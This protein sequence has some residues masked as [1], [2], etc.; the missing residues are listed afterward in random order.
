MLMNWKNKIE[1]IMKKLFLFVLMAVIAILP[2]SC[3]KDEPAPIII[4]DIELSDD[5]L[6]FDFT[7]GVK[8]LSIVIMRNNNMVREEWQ[9]SGGEPWCTTSI[10]NGNAMWVSF[11][12]EPY[13]GPNERKAFFTFSCGDIKKEFVICQREYST[14]I[15]ISPT[16]TLADALRHLSLDSDDIRALKIIGKLSKDD[17]ATLRKMTQLKKLDISEV[18][19][20]ELPYRAFS[21]DLEKLILPKTLTQIRNECF[22]GLGVKS[23]TIPANV[24]NIEPNELRHISTLENIDFEQGSKLKILSGW[25]S[26]GVFSGCNIVSIKIPASVETIKSGAFAGCRSLTTISFEKNSNLKDIQSGLAAELESPTSDVLRY[27]YY[28]AFADCSSLTSI[29][30][31]ASVET[32][33]PTAFLRCHSLAKV[34]FEKGSKLKEISGTCYFGAKRSPATYWHG[35]FSDCPITSIEIPASVERIQECAFKGCSQL[36]S[37]T[38]EK[39]SKLKTIGGMSY[40]FPVSFHLP[41]TQAYL[42]AFSDCTALTSIE[43]PASVES[44]EECAFKGCSQL[45]SVTFEKGSKLKTIG[46]RYYQ[47][48]KD[49]CRYIAFGAF[50]GCPITSIEIPASVESIEE[51][52][53]QDCSQLASVTFEKG[54]KLKTIGGGAVYGGVISDSVIHYYYYGGFANTALQLFAIDAETPPQ[55][56]KYAFYGVNSSAVLKVPSKSVIKY[57]MAYVWKN[58]SSILG[59]DE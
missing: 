54:S 28:G 24:E 30:I 31:P 48:N 47:Y 37:V 36:A 44:I 10:T 15:E 16:E 11:K 7:G 58:F 17:F 25:G 57:K 39:G 46:G 9:L 59:L 29:E 13:E 32:I 26:S 56:N 34:T 51:C 43:I 12:V 52:A 18:D 41:S 14:I 49:N 42:G 45:A 23:I 38:F 3:S 19:I 53:F 27:T 55:C 35:V 50:T 1:K 20:T 22:L 2:N 6:I 4:T 21:Q 5:E 40:S 8:S 33:G